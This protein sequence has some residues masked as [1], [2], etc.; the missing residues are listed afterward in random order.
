MLPHSRQRPPLIV[1]LDKKTALDLNNFHPQDYT[2]YERQVLAGK[3]RRA[4]SKAAK[5]MDFEL[6]AVLRDSVRSLT[7]S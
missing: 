4:M 7:N 2:P 6:T 3:L 5:E 1:N